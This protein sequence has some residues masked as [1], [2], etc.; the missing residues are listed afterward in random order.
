MDLWMVKLETNG[1]PNS[2]AMI[3]RGVMFKRDLLPLI[4]IHIYIFFLVPPTISSKY[5][6]I[7]T[8]A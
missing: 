2:D 1:F 8:Q 5:L 6:F 7:F 3:K 4:Q